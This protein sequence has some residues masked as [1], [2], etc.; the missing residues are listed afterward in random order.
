MVNF[1]FATDDVNAFLANTRTEIYGTDHVD[2]L[3]EPLSTWPGALNLYSL[4]DYRELHG[5]STPLSQDAAEKEPAQP[6]AEGAPVY[7][8]ATGKCSDGSQSWAGWL[9]KWEACFFGRE[10]LKRTIC[11][12]PQSTTFDGEESGLGGMPFV[13]PDRMRKIGIMLV[14]II[15]GLLFIYGGSK[16]L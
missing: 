8:C 16:N 14:L 9:D 11:A 12:P 3:D 4:P 13:S 15:L 2:S 7:D 1:P 5:L 6:G 10:A